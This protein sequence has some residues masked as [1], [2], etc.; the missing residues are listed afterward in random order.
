MKNKHAERYPTSL[1]IRKMQIKT[2]K[3]YYYATTR[4]TKVTTEKMEYY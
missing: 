2:L 3:I 1:I 4:M